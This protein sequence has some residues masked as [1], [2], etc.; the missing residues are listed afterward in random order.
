MSFVTLLLPSLLAIVIYMAYNDLA[1]RMTRTQSSE[2]KSMEKLAADVDKRRVPERQAGRSRG[3]ACQA[4]CRSKSVQMLQEELRKSDASVEKIGTV[5]ADK[6]QLEEAVGRS[7]A[8]LAAV[9]NDVQGLAKDLQAL[10]P[11]R[12]E[13]AA[14]RP[15]AARSTRYRRAC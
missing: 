15:C 12:E 13:L 4:G 10:A 14:S 2:L 8:G 1:L 6:K 11:F 3:G 7:E 5:K 9:S